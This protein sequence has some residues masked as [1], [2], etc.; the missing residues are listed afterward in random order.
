MAATVQVKVKK[1]QMLKKFY[2]LALCAGLAIGAHAV[3]ARPVARVFTQPDGTKITVLLRG[4]ESF[5]FYQSLDGVPLVRQTDGAFYYALCEDGRL[6]SSAVLAHEADVRTDAEVSLLQTD[7]AS[8][9]GVS[10][11][12]SE[13]MQVRAR[14][15][16]EAA[17]ARRLK[18]PARVGDVTGVTGERKGLVILVN[19]KDKKFSS[20]STR[21]AFDDMMN[22]EGYAENGNGG[23]VHDYFYAQ[24]YGKF[25]LTFDVVGPVTV[26]KNMAAYGG[27]DTWGNDTDPAGMVYEAC[28]LADSQVN[29]ADYDWNGDGEVDQVYL[30]YAGYS[31]AA[32]AE[33]NTIWPH[34]WTLYSGGYNLVLD[35]VRINTYGCSSELYG[36][37]GTRMDGVGTPCHEFSHCLGLPDFYDT[38][39]TY[40]NYGMNFWSIMDIGCYAGDGFVPVG[41]TSYERMVSGWLEPTVLTEPTTVEGMKALTESPEA[42][43]IYNDAHKDEYYM[44]ENR[45]KTG[46]DAQAPGHGMIVT[47]V[48]Y[49]ASAWRN[50]TVNSRYNKEGCAVVPADNRKTMASRAG[51]P[52]PGTS[53]NTELT[54]DSK[55][56]ATLYNSNSDGRKYLGKPIT[57]IAEK[58]GLISFKFMGGA[59][60]GIAQTEAILPT[61]QVTVYALDGRLV[62][63]TTYSQ[64]SCQLA[65]GVYVLRLADGRTIK[66][67]CE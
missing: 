55:P 46:W 49:E 30:I 20:T 42:Y 25:D 1:T 48:N 17:Q 26:S 12:A 29:F 35:G 32:G 28:K 66:A 11:L 51:D 8:M 27:N 59:S 34:E 44:L 67:A 31:E 13:R 50:N 14:Q 41:Y 47:H 62:R 45:Q 36:T 39:G 37:S 23:S 60:T 10:R 65:P 4:D 18:S 54:D 3:P 21:Q 22:K 5:H 56:A 40:N 38:S 43:I 58:S 61:S 57:D 64:W 24:S 15:R 7:A 16:A 33:D 19:F 63:Q 2:T 52:Y 9:E 6:K 53:R